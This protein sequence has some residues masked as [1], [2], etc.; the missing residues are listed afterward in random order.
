MAGPVD[1]MTR[2]DR[3][4]KNMAPDAATARAERLADERERRQEEHWE[5]LHRQLQFLPLMFFL[6]SLA[7]AAVCFL[8]VVVFGLS[9]AVPWR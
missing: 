8:C 7:I 2:A 4:A 9:L 1:E 6:W 3:W 5:R